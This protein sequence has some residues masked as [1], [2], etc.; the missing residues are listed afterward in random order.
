MKSIN[1]MVSRVP[2]PAD[3][4]P[5]DFAD[6]G[7]DEGYEEEA[8]VL[9]KRNRLPFF[10]RGSIILA[11]LVAGV[12]LIAG[13]AFYKWI[14]PILDFSGKPTPVAVKTTAVRPK[15]SVTPAPAVR[16]PARSTARSPRMNG[17]DPPFRPA[18]PVATRT[19]K[20]P[21][22]PPPPAKGPSPRVSAAALAM[23]ETDKKK[24]ETSLPGPKAG[25]SEKKTPAPTARAS[26][27]PGLTPTPVPGK[28][29]TVEESPPKIEPAKKEPASPPAS[30]K[31]EKPVENPVKAVK[32]KAALPPKRVDKV[33]PSPKPKTPMTITAKAAKTP[34]RTVRSRRAPSS[35]PPRIAK[36]PSGRYSIQVGACRT[37]K[38]VKTL[39]RRLKD[40]GLEPLTAKSKSG[41]LTLV[42]TG[43]YPT[44]AAARAEMRNV[45]T[46]GFKGSH[47][48]KR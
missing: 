31:R 16:L 29:E 9:E 17:S 48:I 36:A 4:P 42:L 2:L 32:E 47:A 23:T 20:G 43:A 37:S 12:I 45:I 39:S 40:S 19:L 33:L 24:Q 21:G 5:L 18:S 8:E 28:P 44:W 14:S 22:A 46:K 10:V 27:V 15:K 11:L 30:V 35:G 1:L 25:E 38:C 26:V 3:G 6:I 13:G 41:R 34:D 7:A